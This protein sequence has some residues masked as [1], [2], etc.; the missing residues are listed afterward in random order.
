M[1]VPELLQY[2]CNP[3]ELTRVMHDLLSDK[4]ASERMVL[5]LQ[6]LTSSLS[7]QQADCSISELIIREIELFEPKP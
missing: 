5:R 6:Q 7:A 3:N 1:I 4:K 2:D